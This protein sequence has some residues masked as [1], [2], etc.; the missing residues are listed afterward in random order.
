MTP[1]RG[2]RFDHDQTFED[3]C[4][5]FSWPA[6]RPRGPGARWRPSHGSAAAPAWAAT[7]R[8]RT[9]RWAGAGTAARSAR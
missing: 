2:R 3:S 4:R 6:P 9:A 5:W 8:P 7:N 1:A